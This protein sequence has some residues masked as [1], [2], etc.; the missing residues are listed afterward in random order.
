MSF[1]QREF[2]FCMIDELSCT[3]KYIHTYL[4]YYVFLNYVSLESVSFKK[5]VSNGIFFQCEFQAFIVR[6]SSHN[7]TLALSVKSTEDKGLPEE[8]IEHY[9]IQQSE[10]SPT[11][12]SLECSEHQFDNVLSLVYHY[13]TTK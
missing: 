2:F 12:L 6:Q 1:S 3:L 10:N 5:L 7:N 9:L 11:K 4:V 13:S 8:S